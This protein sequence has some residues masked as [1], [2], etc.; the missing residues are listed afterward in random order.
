MV[1][2]TPKSSPKVASRAASRRLFRVEVRIVEGPVDAQ[3]VKK[4]KVMSR[5]IEARGDQTLE[6][7]HEAIFAAFDRHDEHLYEFQI[8]GKGPRDPKAKRYVLPM[9]LEDPFG[10]EEFAGDVTRTRL[11]SLGLTA[12][13]RFAYWFDFG[14]DWWHQIEVL[15]VEGTAPAG[16]F[17]RV[18][19]RK[20]E[21]PPQYADA[22]E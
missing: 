4:N 9:C 2:K 15:A 12:G 5:T 19:A 10:D 22:E 17:P 7:L 20:G 14:D 13:D 16:R 1:R 18:V 8:G 11:D 6:A 21:S 3:F